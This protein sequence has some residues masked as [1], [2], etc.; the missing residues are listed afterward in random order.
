MKDINENEIKIATK[1]D[2]S[3]KFSLPEEWNEEAEKR[4]DILAKKEALETISA[5]ELRELESLSELR[6]T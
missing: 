5:P 4:F 3:L 1:L 2:Q 6:R